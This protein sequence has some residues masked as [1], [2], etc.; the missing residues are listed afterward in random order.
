MQLLSQMQIIEKYSLTDGLTGVSNRRFFDRQLEAEWNRAARNSSPLGLLFLDIDYFKE[1]NDKFGHLSGD[2]ALKTFANVIVETIQR[3]SDYVYR[4]GGE[5]FAVI[6]PETPTD[7]AAV[8]AEKIRINVENT[9]IDFDDRIANITTSIGVGS[10]IP[11]PSTFPH[12]MTEFC[13]ELDKALYKAK[14][15]GRNRVVVW[16]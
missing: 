16:D 7:G 3:K 4:C 15:D 8:V 6:L 2:R 1:F 5:E 13:E 14:R 11:K 10:I 12:G 9:P